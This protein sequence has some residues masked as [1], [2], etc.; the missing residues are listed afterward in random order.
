MSNNENPMRKIRIEKITFNV[1]AGKDQKV[2]EK[3]VKLIKHLTGEA[4]IKTITEKRIQAWGLRAGLPVGCKLTIRN[5]DKIK[6]LLPRLLEAKD[7]VLSKKTFDNRGNFSFGIPEYIDVAGAKYDPDIGI[8]GFEVA[9]TMARPGYRIK[10]RKLFPR[11]IHHNHS[12]SQ[13]EAIDFMKK[14]YTIQLKEEIE[15]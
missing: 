1:G 5:Q 8:M 3:G 12:I 4:P 10:T 15:E 14:N 7:K 13:E 6:E 11:K 9:I 2:L